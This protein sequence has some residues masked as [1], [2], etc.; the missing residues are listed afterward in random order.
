M[1]ITLLARGPP[2]IHKHLREN[3]LMIVS[4]ACYCYFA[5]PGR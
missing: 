4:R 1:Y 2:E 5:H 3:G